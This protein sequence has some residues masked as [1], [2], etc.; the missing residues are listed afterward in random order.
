MIIRINSSFW[1]LMD[2]RLL[3]ADS[4][5]NEMLTVGSEGVFPVLLLIRFMRFFPFFHN[6]PTHIFSPPLH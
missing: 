6:T 5:R 4:Q 2:L 3:Q 1:F